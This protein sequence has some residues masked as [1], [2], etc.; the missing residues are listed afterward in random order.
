MK[1]VLPHKIKLW[2]VSFLRHH[3]I[4]IWNR[5]KT[6]FL[7]NLEIPRL[8]SDESLVYIQGMRIIIL[9]PFRNIYT[10]FSLLC[11]AAINS[12]PEQLR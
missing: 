5:S 2:D 3:R 7:R 8:F 11:F 1:S 10:A 12:K 9:F 6:V 4:A